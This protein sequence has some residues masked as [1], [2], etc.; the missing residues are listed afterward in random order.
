MGRVE[1]RCDLGEQIERP[2]GVQWTFAGEQ[3]AQVAPS[4]NRIAR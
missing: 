1:R 4:T 3:L 2:A